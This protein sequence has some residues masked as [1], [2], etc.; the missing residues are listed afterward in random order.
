M[1]KV[2][3]AL[4]AVA[5]LAIMF[6]PGNIRLASSETLPPVPTITAPASGAAVS[7][8]VTVKWSG[9]ASPYIY[10]LWRNGTA[11]PGCIDL[12]YPS[13]QC[14]DSG[15]SGSVTYN[16]AVCS[17]LNNAGPCT[18]S[19][20]VSVTVGSVSVPLPPPGPT[21]P[22]GTTPPPA[23]IPGPPVLAAPY[24]SGTLVGVYWSA[25]TSTG[26]VWYNLSRR[27]PPGSGSWT[28]VANALSVT[29]YSSDAGVS[30]GS[31]YE[32]R[33]NVCNSSG[34]SADSNYQTALIGSSIS[35]PPPSPL[36]P[37]APAPTPTPSP[38]PPPAS[39]TAPNAPSNLN[40]NLSNGGTTV[41][42]NWQDN[43]TNE[44]RFEIYRQ[45]SGGIWGYWNQAGANATSFTD[46]T[47]PSGSYYYQVA[48]CNGLAVNTGCSMGSNTVGPIVI[49]GSISPSPTPVASSTPVNSALGVYLTVDGYH[50]TASRAAPASYTLS[51][52][53]S[54][55]PK[56][57]TMSVSSPGSGGSTAL[58]I[59]SGS[60][61]LTGVTALGT[62]IYTITCSNG[63]GVASDS[64]S[65]IVTT[66]PAIG[67]TSTPQIIVSTSTSPI[68]AVNTGG[69][70]QGSVRDSGGQPVASVYVHVF[71]SDFSLNFNAVTQNDGSF[72]TSLPAGTYS[73]EIS[74]P[75]ARADLIK[76]TPQSVAITNG[77]VQAIILQF[78][79]ASKT[80]KGTAA[81][82]G[83]QPVTDAQVGAYSSVTQQWTAATTDGNGNFILRVAGGTWQIGIRPVSPLLA[84]WSA[85]SQFPQVTFANDASA[86]TQTVN[87][88][89]PSLSAQLTVHT[90]DENGNTIQNAGV[91]VDTVSA[92]A[93]TLPGTQTA[94]A[95]FR[96]SDSNGTAVF[97]LQGGTYYV[98]AFL[99]PEAGY[100]N[101]DER[102]LSLNVKDTKD[103]S[104]AFHKRSSATAATV[105]QG[106]TKLNDGTLTDA[107]VWGWSEKGDT[108]QAHSGANGV[109][110]L[111][112]TSG[113]WHVGAGKELNSLPYK[114]S[115][116]TV[117]VAASAVSVEIILARLGAALPPP[118]SVNQPSTQQIVA[119]ATD[120]AKATIPEGAAG[121]SGNI[122]V[123]VKPTIEA[124]SQAAAKV[125]STVYDVSITNAS[126][127]A[128]SS[129][130]KEI[131]ITIPYSDDDLKAQGITADKLVPSYYDESTGTWV[132]VD[133]YVIDK[134]HHV[135]VIRVKHLT[136]FA[137]VAAADITPPSAPANIT[138]NADGSGA[139]LISWTNPVSDFDHAKIYR[140][141][142]AGSLGE[143]LLNN[144]LDT[145][146]RDTSVARGTKYYYTV[147][148][149]DP[150]GNESANSTQVSVTAQGT[151]VGAGGKL[152]R[153]LKVGSRGDDVK[154]LQ[155]ILIRE[156]V[157]PEGIVSGYYGKLTSQ[158]VVRFQEKYADDILKPNGLDHG[159]GFVGSSTRAKL[160]L[161]LH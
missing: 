17:G 83:G 117:D 157:Y 79:A 2:F 26:T 95:V 33:V 154:T 54:G 20:S 98:R 74:P 94:S 89:I 84:Q 137:L 119:Q 110:S 153:N 92:S 42:L 53:V 109:F 99:P 85:P 86:E 93:Q 31:S 62:Q 3:W 145:Q 50:G 46:A 126:G 41:N 128:V 48:A 70:L 115:E 47:L 51:W 12:A 158:A 142:I 25:S 7:S 144:V 11:V 106:V 90:V 61:Y 138:A 35:P 38:T 44:T 37:P 65:V 63:I 56:S 29:S 10:T 13:N 30:V 19:N 59:P 149:V 150:A 1:G 14:P 104:L 139:V 118:V 127:T 28:A 155:G 136:R 52:T 120:G 27:T 151:F 102:P 24:V 140:S 143:I 88:T 39:S 72:G 123:E 112:V 58:S 6:L 40:F 36:P 81:F 132:K 15:A 107:F 9:T 87:F 122:N 114:S 69:F 156:G 130:Q 159:T 108:A 67:A 75:S 55:S 18:G 147:V 73:V 23:P 129:F 49:G 16:V 134:D 22:P 116:L 146:A 82:V 105:L 121:S 66:P 5:V 131:E 160:N 125:V 152:L 148:A 76:P 21:P 141:T 64:V 124:P 135:A 43:S 77:A 8:P 133:S 103:I 34:C 113:R 45:I 71:T 4:L 80:I 60:V 78:S 161:L 101:P 96:K 57:C 100:F 97:Y 91:V 32:Y 68:A 111:P